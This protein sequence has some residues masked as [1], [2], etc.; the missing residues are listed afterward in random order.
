MISA[1]DIL[2]TADKEG[3]LPDLEGLASR[4]P[5]GISMDEKLHR[6]AEFILKYEQMW[7]DVGNA[8]P[9][10][11]FSGFKYKEPLFLDSS[12]DERN[13]NLKASDYLNVLKEYMRRWAARKHEGSPTENWY[14]MQEEF[15]KHIPIR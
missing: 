12:H 1:I 9:F 14:K 3:V 7:H 10:R 4:M 6:V 11:Q 8:D 15:S 2:S 13:L 5:V